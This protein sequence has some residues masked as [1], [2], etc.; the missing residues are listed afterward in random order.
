MKEMKIMK[1]VKE[2]EIEIKGKEWEK[3][4]DKA[5]KKKLPELKVPGFRKGS[6]PKEVYLKKAGI[7]SLFMDASDIAIE[8]AYKKALDKDVNPVVQPSVEIVSVSKDSVKFKFTI[9]TRPEIKLGAYTKLGIKKEEIKVSKKEID[10]EIEKLRDNM[11]EILN[12]E[13]GAVEKGNIAIIDFDGVV[14]GKKLDGGSGKDYS[15]EIG[16]NTFIPGFE[17][18]LV[19]M[20]I[21]DTK[22]INLKFPEDYVE[23]LKGKDVTFTVTIKGIKERVVPALGKDFYEDLAIDGVDSKESLEEYIK[24]ELSEKKNDEAENKYVDELLHKATDNM[25]VEINNEIIDEEVHHMIHQYEDELK[26]QGASL[27][28]YLAM[29]KTKME[30]LE[31]MMK[32]QAIARIKTRFLLEEIVDKENIKASAAEIKEEVKNNAAKYGMKDE[33]FLDAMGGN[34][35]IA[36]DIKMKKAV[37]II[38][39]A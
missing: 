26:Y 33:E 3:D 30:D 9:I 11:A 19:G 36:Y 34:D 10:E 6:V 7:E 18:E 16:S 1:N 2:I 5:F 8:D 39:E 25:E 29:T 4:L 23:N 32:P 15:L 20:S 27:Q 14:D 35:A 17:D 31:N 13:N 28:Q 24:S 22:K 37:E 12:K 21:G 38:K